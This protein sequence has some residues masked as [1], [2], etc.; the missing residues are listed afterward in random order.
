MLPP[1]IGEPAEVI[2]NLAA[3]STQ[4]VP[5][6]GDSHRGRRV[7]LVGGSASCD[8]A[9]HQAHRSASLAIGLLGAAGCMPRGRQVLAL[10]KE[11]HGPPAFWIVLGTIALSGALLH[12]TLWYRA[13]SQG[14]SYRNQRYRFSVLGLLAWAALCFARALTLS[15]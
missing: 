7:G 15:R 8:R 12:G 4:L 1:L 10:V 2:M 14:N 9:A 6:I 11:H 5:A 13:R 3:L